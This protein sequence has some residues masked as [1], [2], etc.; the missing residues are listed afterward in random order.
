[1]AEADCPNDDCEH[2]RIFHDGDGNDEPFMCCVEGCICEP[3][4]H[5]AQI[6]AI[7]D[8]GWAKV[9]G[10]WYCKPPGC[11]VNA[12]N[13]ANHEVIE[14]DDGTITVSPSILYTVEHSKPPYR[15]HGYLEHGVW[16]EV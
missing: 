3:D 10:A 1:M 11:P 9:G 7:P 8:G 6:Q 14:H 16:R 15:Y 4:S 12:A 2:P 13:L 5:Y